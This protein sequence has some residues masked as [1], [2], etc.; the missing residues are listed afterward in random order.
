VAAPGVLPSMPRQVLFIENSVG[1][2]GSTV[3]LTTLLNHL[4]RSVF[5]PHVVVSRPEQAT[6]LRQQLRE[7]TDVA[8]I[9][10]SGGLKGARWLRRLL[11]PSGIH[12]RGL[13]R[14]VW[15]A[16]G[17]LDM[18]LV[19][20]P[21]SLRLRRFTRGRGIS[22]IHQN[23]GFDIGAVFLSAMLG[24][25]L[26]AYQRGDEWNSLAVR[27][28]A[29]RVS[30]FIAN[31]M[32]TRRSLAA[33]GI[34][35]NRVRVIYPPVDLER[36]T[37]NRP[38]EEVRESLGLPAGRPCFGMIGMLL[39]WKGH[40]VFLR[41][42]AR[43][44]ERFPHARA[45]V[46]GGPPSGGEAYASELRDLARELGIDDRVIFSGFRSDVADVF[47]VLDVVV[48]ASIEPEPFGRVIVEAMVMRRP[49]VATRAGG[50][51]EII[52][53]GQT[54]LLV[55]PG[56]V[57]HLAAAVIDLLVH[58]ERA[59]AIATRGHRDVIRRFAATTNARLVQEVYDEVLRAPDT[60]TSGPA[61]V[62]SN[63]GPKHVL[64][65]AFHF[66]PE[67]S[68]SGVL[69]TLKYVRYLGVHGWRVTVL[70]LD[71]RAYDVQDASLEQQVP[72][73]VRVL[74]TPFLDL[75]R[76]LSIRGVY[77]GSLAVPDRWIGWRPWAM[78]AGRQLMR[79]DPVDL[80]YSTSPHAT[81]HIVAMGLVG[82]HGPPWVADFRD[83]WYEEPPEVGTPRIIHWA[84]RHLERR[85][86]HRASRVVASTERLRHALASRYWTEP[87][88]KFCA[89]P[90]GYDEADFARVPQ[91]AGDRGDELL[92]V[93]VGSLNPVFRDPRPLFAA[94]REAA[95]RGLIDISNVRFRF[96]GG[97]DFGGSP[98]MRRALDE[99]GLAGR[100]EFLPRVDYEHALAE[101]A[102][103][104]LLLLLQASSDT[105]DLVPA[106]LY[107][108]L[109]AGRPV[110]AL[111]G[112]GA[113]A[114][115]MQETA[116]GWVVDPGSPEALC[117]AVSVAY[118][119]WVTGTLEAM[120]ADPGS[121]K[122]FTRERLAGE[123]AAQFD[124]LA[125]PRMVSP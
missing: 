78:R 107:E 38:A 50:P 100:V 64:F 81:A 119:A 7:P 21:Y 98:E 96:L 40:S 63:P 71:R 116:G 28:L 80:V 44:L 13:R 42:A 117:E 57:E 85:V 59:A 29:T 115:L 34:P 53:D 99:A 43:V 69:R 58:P 47:S 109:R 15:Q 16:A 45:V 37:A 19:T 65:V 23:N 2:S 123:L 89:I 101:Q 8:L 4:D 10:P 36:F 9:R 25:P 76:T 82:R 83:P 104:R 49:V 27:W 18:L 73:E 90:N 5:A 30:R 88:E 33:I 97:G 3:S 41:A 114:E 120:A 24:A 92:I 94:V 95:V 72:P 112:P 11:G 35:P 56:D 48:H 26:V 102:N 46:V 91:K 17:V 113:T 74:R 51:T 12:V 86:V 61:P 93:H 111:V 105:A 106:K 22:L 118:R 52:E 70:T 124:A 14:L 66:P 125:G 60:R 103:A 6:F 67:A 122:R 54:G 108:Y 1:L 20:L 110:L 79:T 68:S 87:P 32:S 55:T 31:S 75:K 77:P 39:P 84:G 121:L 62:T